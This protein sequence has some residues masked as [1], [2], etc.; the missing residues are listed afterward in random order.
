MNYKL[1]LPLTFHCPS[2]FKGFDIRYKSNRI[3]ANVRELYTSIF[4]GVG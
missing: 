3:G 1:K 4:N 2:Y